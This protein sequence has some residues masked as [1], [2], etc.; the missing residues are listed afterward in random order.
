MTN[1]RD[2]MFWHKRIKEAGLPEMI[3]SNLDGFAH[4][5][6]KEKKIKRIYREIVKIVH[7]DKCDISFKKDSE[8]AFNAL[9]GLYNQA[10]SD[11]K[12]GNY[13]V[14]RKPVVTIYGKKGEYNLRKIIFSGNVSTVYRGERKGENQ[15]LA[16]K[17]INSPSD[18][19]F[20]ENEAVIL[21]HLHKSASD[22]EKEFYKFIPNLIDSLT[23]S[24]GKSRNRK[25]NIFSLID[26][27]YSLEEVKQQYPKGV[28]LK[29]MFW[30]WK[31]L[32]S[33]LGYAHKNGVV[34]GAVV[35][36]HIMISPA[37]HGLILL[38]WS[39][40][41][42]IDSGHKKIKAINPNYEHLYPQEV[43]KK[44]P[45]SAATD[46]Y[47]AAQC[48]IY[49]LGGDVQKK[50][51]PKSV[52]MEVR[53]FLQSCLIKDQVLRANDAWVLFGEFVEL[54]KQLYGPPKFHPF[55]MPAKSDP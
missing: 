14:S 1:K 13:G 50:E 25:A 4:I 3:F 34:H 51:I 17:I 29:A 49:I 38:D 9:T 8:E 54:L 44:E 5:G 20:A 46:I 42:K 48:M 40:A 52:P 22:Q 47:M 6:D 27:C 21:R 24:D 37:N 2:L 31:R 32:V 33:I 43:F 7:P 53:A 45:A 39:F 19:D 15:E 23:V 30:I 35:P 41:V 28:D 36:S 26:Q 12:S 16:V 18:N 55:H 11:I 10:L